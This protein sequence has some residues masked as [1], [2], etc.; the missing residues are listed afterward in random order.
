MASLIACLEQDLG[1]LKGQNTKE[2]ESCWE[3]SPKGI[4]LL[5]PESLSISPDTLLKVL[6]EVL[7]KICLTML[8]NVS[9]NIIVLSHHISPPV[10]AE[11]GFNADFRASSRIEC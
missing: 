7:I 3:I 1:Y 8:L 10:H 4:E 2:Q 11:V 5:Q 9:P 6:I